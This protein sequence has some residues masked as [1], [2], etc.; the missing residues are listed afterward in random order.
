[1]T[2]FIKYLRFSI[3]K[4][5]LYLF[6]ENILSF[7]EIFNDININPL[8]CIFITWYQITQHRQGPPEDI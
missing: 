2:D 4:Y 3:L 7:Q 8:L 1:M 5:R 6:G